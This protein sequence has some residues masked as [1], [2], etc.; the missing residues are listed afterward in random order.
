MI[1]E[2]RG[3]HRRKPPRKDLYIRVYQIG[4]L[5]SIGSLVLPVRIRDFAAG[6]IFDILAK[7]I[8]WIVPL[9]AHWKKATSGPSRNGV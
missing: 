4:N 1:R 6:R 9:S 5:F 7:T 8:H 3:V 2:S